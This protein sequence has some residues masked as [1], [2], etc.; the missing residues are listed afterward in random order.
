MLLLKISNNTIK[1]K[2]RGEKRY[3]KNEWHVLRAYSVPYTHEKP[4]T[5]SMIIIDGEH[6]VAVDWITL[7]ACGWQL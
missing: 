1:T 7:K 3:K 6:C 2:S 5:I 4:C